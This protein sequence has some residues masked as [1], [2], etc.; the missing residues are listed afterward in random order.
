[1][2]V[3][4]LPLD[5]LHRVLTFTPPAA[6]LATSTACRA[7]HDVVMEDDLWQALYLRVP[8][9]T[10]PYCGGS[11]Q[12]LCRT[13]GLAGRHGA[14]RPLVALDE[15]GGRWVLQAG[16][17]AVLR[18]LREEVSVT[19]FI[20]LGIGMEENAAMALA[21]QLMGCTA[22]CRLAM[23]PAEVRSLAAGLYMWTRWDALSAEGGPPLAHV[24]LLAVGVRL[25]CPQLHLTQGLLHLAL[26][27]SSCAVVCMEAA[28]HY[29]ALE[30]LD[31]LLTP[32]LSPA[33]S[34]ACNL[35]LALADPAAMPAV[36][37]ECP[38][39]LLAPLLARTRLLE[40]S[41]LAMWAVNH[42]DAVTAIRAAPASGCSCGDTHCHGLVADAVM[43]HLR[44]VLRPFRP[45]W[46]AELALGVAVTGPLYHAVVAGE[47]RHAATGDTQPPSVDYWAEHLGSVLLEPSLH[48]SAAAYM[49]AMEFDLCHG[50][51]SNH[52]RV[53]SSSTSSSS[54]SPSPAP[55]PSARATLAIPLDVGELMRSHD[56]FLLTAL[57]RF[58]CECDRLGA[59]HPQ[60]TSP[61]ALKAELAERFRELWR[62]NLEVSRQ[63][64]EEVFETCFSPL[65]LR[66]SGLLVDLPPGDAP[67][68]PAAPDGPAPAAAPPRGCAADTLPPSPLWDTKALKRFYAC[69]LDIAEEYCMKAK[70][71][72][73]YEV[74]AHK[75]NALLGRVQRAFRAAPEARLRPEDVAQACEC[76]MQEVQRMAA[77]GIQRQDHM[78]AEQQRMASLH[79]KHLGLRME[80][81]RLQRLLDFHTRAADAALRT[82][83]QRQH[84]ME[85]L[86]FTNPLPR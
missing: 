41:T 28:N 32:L 69:F 22:G 27:V 79:G 57:Q 63:Y 11:W 4:R 1:M 81:Q 36:G 53:R 62:R 58:A 5:A 20:P 65:E 39:A 9:H 64:C 42:F 86:G 29:A 76:L 2:A 78:R 35:V 26:R 85:R 74:L 75:G 84:K 60:L 12:A 47:V 56:H 14:L 43:E 10:R 67:A 21:F 50:D 71:P 25:P 13:F 82:Q 70:G 19:C 7:L 38:E 68:G 16:A 55:L 46:L 6:L 49:N 40:A 15:A 45:G 8:S 24:C 59:V 37:E 51:P 52:L 23:D 77:D 17:D 80:V 83:Q 44:P 72:R 48:S 18:D 73:K 33:A 30:C 34:P 3:L 66:Y 61:A 31:V 54:S